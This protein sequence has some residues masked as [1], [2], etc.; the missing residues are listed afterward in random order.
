M[1]AHIALI[2]ALLAAALPLAA[3]N[4]GIGTNAPLEKLHVVGNIR[5]STLA[6]TGTRVVGADGSLTGF[7]GGLEV[8]AWLLDHERGALFARP[9]P[10]PRR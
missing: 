5:S 7:A 6:G 4:V 8:K 10:A 3:Q 1:K 2:V 9:A